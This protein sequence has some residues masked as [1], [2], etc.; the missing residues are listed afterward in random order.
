MAGARSTITF[1]PADQLTTCGRIADAIISGNEA[2]PPDTDAAYTPHGNQSE[3]Q[4][5]VYRTCPELG[6]RT[7]PPSRI[8][9]KPSRADPRPRA[10]T[11]SV[12]LPA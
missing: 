1:T 7:Y 12:A 9:Y 8:T 11:A 6:Q 10:E 4:I 2:S 3:W 5:D